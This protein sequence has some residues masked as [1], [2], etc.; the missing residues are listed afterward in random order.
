MSTICCPAVEALRVAH[1]SPEKSEMIAL[2]DDVTRPL[3]SGIHIPALVRVKSVRFKFSRVF[4]AWILGTQPGW[5]AWLEMPRSPSRR[6]MRA[7]VAILDIIDV[8]L[9]G[10]G[11]VVFANNCIAG[12]MILV[13]MFT[14]QTWPALT[15]TFAL[16]VAT[17]TGTIAGGREAVKAGLLGFNGILTGIALGYFAGSEWW[18][19]MLAIIAFA[20]AASTLV[21]MVLATALGKDIPGM[22]LPFNIVTL[23]TLLSLYHFPYVPSN[24]L[25]M[26]ASLQTQVVWQGTV[27]DAGQFLASALKGV[28]EIYIADTV[29]AGALITAAMFLTSPIRALLA[30]TGALCGSVVGLALGMPPSL[31]YSGLLGYNAS[32][33]MTAIAGEFFQLQW[34]SAALAMM[35]TIGTV[36][37]FGSFRTLFSP[38]GVPILTFP[39]CMSTLCAL[40]L[41][42]GSFGLQA[43]QLGEVQM[44][45]ATVPLGH[46]APPEQRLFK[47]LVL[48]FPRRK[49]QRVLS[50][51]LKRVKST[52]LERLPSKRLPK[53][54]ETLLVGPQLT[55]EEI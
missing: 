34:R 42:K 35:C 25:Y 2:Q 31:I 48:D 20:A 37:L 44:S 8:T 50:S 4:V 10:A 12:A 13:A 28:A 7:C 11:Q 6:V 43:T 17:I 36:V 38:F 3:S 19:P 23:T 29:T 49:L 47:R 26:T 18:W 24:P 46:I 39:F 5:R 14:W 33:C 45:D 52:R 32:L 54:K 22:T 53:R 27:A 9:R 21:T 51:G 30:V 40:L 15:G 1:H 41:R 55:V 16:I